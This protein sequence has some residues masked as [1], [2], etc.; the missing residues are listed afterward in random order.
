[1]LKLSSQC[2]T[3]AFLEGLASHVK[4]QRSGF[5]A[6]EPAPA[7]CICFCVNIQL[8]PPLK[9]NANPT[10]AKAAIGQNQLKASCIDGWVSV[11]AA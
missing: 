2:S 8:M 3:P 9:S 1:M 6:G 4:G 5:I 7:A 11:S 10:I